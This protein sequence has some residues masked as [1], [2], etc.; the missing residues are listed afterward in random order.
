MMDKGG[1]A[2]D[3]RLRSKSLIFMQFS[4]KNVAK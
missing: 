2:N 4:A 3:V 1:G